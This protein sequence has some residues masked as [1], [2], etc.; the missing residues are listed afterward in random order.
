MQKQQHYNNVQLYQIECFNLFIIAIYSWKYLDSNH[1][2]WS[3]NGCIEMMLVDI[4]NAM[5]ETPTLLV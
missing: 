4:C 5:I 3:N 2:Y 1:F